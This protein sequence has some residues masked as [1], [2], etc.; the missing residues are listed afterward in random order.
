MSFERIASFLPSSTEILYELGAGDQIV[1]VTHECNYAS[2]AKTKPTVLNCTFGS[3]EMSSKQIDQ[4]MIEL[5][6]SGGDIYAIDENKLRRGRPDLI[7]AQGTCEVCAPFTKEINRAVSIL[8]YKPSVLV[9]DPHDLEGILATVIQISEKVGR[10]S[11]GRVIVMSLQD[12]IDGIK[13]RTVEKKNK[14]CSAENSNRN[15]PRVLC[16]EWLDPFFAAGHWVPEMVEIAG[17]VNGLSSRAQPSRR[18]HVQEIADFDPEKIIL[19]PCGFSIE[20][21][22]KEARFLADSK[23]WSSLTAV[24]RGEVYAVNANAYFSKPGIRTITGLEILAK[25]IDPISFADLKLPP[26]SVSNM[27]YNLYSRST[28]H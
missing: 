13:T 19:M 22:V 28:L 25:I 2:D 12:R 16:L 15:N 27:K 5:L 8:D 3:D 7:I 9:I 4:K 10:I 18:V 1:G 21:T 20:R 14:N 11:H 26:N 17:V 6:R 23:Q 24:E